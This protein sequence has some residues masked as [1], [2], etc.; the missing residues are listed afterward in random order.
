[1]IAWLVDVALMSII[2]LVA[3]WVLGILAGRLLSW[4]RKPTPNG[5]PAR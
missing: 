5:Y 3:L 4:G 2:I 1:M